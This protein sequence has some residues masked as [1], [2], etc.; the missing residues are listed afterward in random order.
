MHKSVLVDLDAGP[1][2][3]V[4]SLLD[5][6]VLLFPVA[7]HARSSLF[8]QVEHC[9]TGFERGLDYLLPL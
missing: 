4:D 5:G 2:G 6:G 8:G 1:L 3:V 9:H 7:D